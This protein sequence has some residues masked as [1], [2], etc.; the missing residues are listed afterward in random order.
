MGK[1]VPLKE[2]VSFVKA[3]EDELRSVMLGLFCEEHVP[4]EEEMISGWFHCSVCIASA[5]TDYESSHK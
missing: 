2:L 4:E 1:K 3:H 5:R